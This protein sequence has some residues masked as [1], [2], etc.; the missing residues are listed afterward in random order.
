MSDEPNPTS[1][2]READPVGDSDGVSP[3]GTH[4]RVAR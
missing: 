1:G 2:G 4:G 3:G